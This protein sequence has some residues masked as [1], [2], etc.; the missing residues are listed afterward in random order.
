MADIRRGVGARL[1]QQNRE[2][3]KSGLDGTNYDDD[4]D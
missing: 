4:N 2:R 1:F 3:W